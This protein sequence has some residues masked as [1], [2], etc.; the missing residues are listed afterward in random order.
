[1]WSGTYM[2]DEL[3]KDEKQVRILAQD[4]THMIFILVCVK[5]S[6]LVAAETLQNNPH[7]HIEALAFIL[8][9]EFEMG[10]SFLFWHVIYRQV[11]LGL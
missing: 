7:K 2:R 9:G 8:L 4:C 11:L 6:A 5:F 10:L 3:V 1:M